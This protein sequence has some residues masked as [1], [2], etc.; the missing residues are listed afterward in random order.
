M[1]LFIYLFL[2]T[3][4][5]VS[6]DETAHKMLEATRRLEWIDPYG[7]KPLE[8]RKWK[9]VKKNLSEFNVSTVSQ[10]KNDTKSGLIDILI[11]SSLYINI[12][13]EINQYTSD[14][15]SEGYS[16]QVDTASGMSIG[17]LRTYLSGIAGL[18]GVVFVGELPIAWY[19]MNNSEEFPID[20]YFTDLDGNWVD[21]DADGLFDDH[22]GNVE[23]EIW[24]GRIYARPLLWG[25]E[26]SLI[27]KYFAKNHQYRNGGLGIPQRALSFV[28]DDWSY[29][30]D[31]GLDTIYSDVTVINDFDS[32]V[33]N[34][35]RE[36][37]L[38]GYE[39]IHIC[40]HSSPWGH[41]FKDSYGYAGSV[42]N[43]EIFVL[44]PQAIF[45]NLFAC[46]G[47][48]YVEENYSAGWYIFG[49]NPGLTIVGSTKTGSMLYFDD[50]YKWLSQ[51]NDIGEAFKKWF[52]QRGESSRSWF[53]GTNIIGDPTLKTLIS[54]DCV[55]DESEKG[56]NDVTS[57]WTTPEKIDSHPESDGN[58]DIICLDGKQWVVF[59]SGRSLDN[60]RSD[61]YCKYNENGNWSDVMNIGPHVYWD[62]NPTIDVYQGKPFAVW[63]NFGN[64]YN[65]KYSSYEN[66]NWSPAEMISNDPSWDLKPELASY[67]DTL[68]LAW[69][70][71]RNLDSDIYV[72]Y[73]SDSLWSTPH[74]ITFSGT[75]ELYP[76]LVIDSAGTPWIFYS[77]YMGDSSQI[78]Y[79]FKS[80]ISWIT[81]SPISGNQIKAYHP[82]ATVDRNGQILVSWQNFDDITGNIYY[83]KYNESLWNI[84]LRIESPCNNNVFPAM[85]SDYN[86]CS[87]I[88]WQG[89]SSGE[90]D[91]YTSYMQDSVW[92]DPQ[93]VGLNG[94]G[95]NPEIGVDKSRVWLVWQNYTSDSW[96]I[97]S[98]QMLLSGV[99]EDDEVKPKSFQILDISPNP[100][101]DITSIYFSIPEEGKVKINVYNIAGRKV[102]SI[103]N[104]RLKKGYH[105]VLWDGRDENGHK[106]SSGIY[107]I[108]IKY[109]GETITGKVT[110][111]D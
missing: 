58:P 91:I 99:T 101:R 21:S 67:D 1:L 83:N 10:Y 26:V 89:Y 108:R 52:I 71:R 44:N 92:S 64:G 13:D 56:K 97:Y 32:T 53:Y 22:T 76:S 45:Y 48:R 31:C 12:I 75:D 68:W 14:L 11:E 100:F 59:Q 72:S 17:S 87:W 105:F 47:T 66:G 29:F 62:F 90:W 16:V 24:L 69:Q 65:L 20:L 39:W 18:S 33:A 4:G 57:E 2:L 103:L 98:S 51:N 86:G 95:I 73:F 78:Y 104:E 41:T 74:S 27:K 96:D 40:A 110:I 50:F 70:T 88:A 36:E 9:T 55:L 81:G 61:I 46:S 77:R 19:E 80:G 3:S 30:E 85:T 82:S 63:A 35:Y 84:P 42:F 106:T 102:Q 49:D 5:S 7:R 93:V 25:N 38:S 79:S 8:F 37:F 23:P 28:D 107:F 43:Y 94:A 6:K 15:T 111:L 109:R 60:G 34:N 54:F